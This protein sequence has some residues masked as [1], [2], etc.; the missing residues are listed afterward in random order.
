MR[1]TLSFR[2]DIERDPLGDDSWWIDGCPGP[3]FPYGISLVHYGLKTPEDA[4]EMIMM[5]AVYQAPAW[6]RVVSD[7]KIAVD[8]SARLVR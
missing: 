1:T 7:G 5:K 6:C 4:R 8:T 3:D 2:V